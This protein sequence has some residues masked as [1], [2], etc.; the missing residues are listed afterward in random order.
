MLAWAAAAAVAVRVCAAVLHPLQCSLAAPACSPHAAQCSSWAPG[1]RSNACLTKRGG[2]ALRR[3]LR[4]AVTEGLVHLQQ[5]RHSFN[6]S[7]RLTLTTLPTRS[8]LQD[9]YLHLPAGPGAHA[10]V[11]GGAALGGCR[12]LRRW[13]R[14]R[15]A[16]CQAANGRMKSHLSALHEPLASWPPWEVALVPCRRLCIKPSFSLPSSP[17][18]PQII[19]SILFIAIQ[20]SAFIWYCASYIPYGQSF[21]KRML[22]FSS[23]DAD[24]G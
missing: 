14:R 4:L 8:C 18:I 9:V 19:L 11:G 16:A 21:I 20:F 6:P 3:C 5:M 10:C 24:D 12:A 22:G 17:P 7:F 1:R 23:A 13:V 2:E 15:V